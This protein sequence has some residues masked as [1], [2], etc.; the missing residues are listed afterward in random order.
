[1]VCL[2]NHPIIILRRILTQTITASVIMY[3][4]FPNPWNSLILFLI[5]IGGLIVVFIYTTRLASNEK[6]KIQMFDI[7]TA[8]TV[9]ITIF[10]TIYIATRRDI[11]LILVSVSKMLN[12]IFSQSSKFLI[13]AIMMYLFFLIVVTTSIVSLNQAPLRPSSYTYD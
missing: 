1:M 11:N 7:F 8:C 3:I 5:F 10:T 6:I 9:V 13:I 4:I 12:S 2:L